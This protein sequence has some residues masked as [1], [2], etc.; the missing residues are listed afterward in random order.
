[1]A[2]KWK[3]TGDILD[4]CNCDPGCPCLFYSDPTKGHCDSLWAFH[5][6]TGNYGDVKLDGLN[7][8]MVTMSPG[9]FWKGNLK[10]AVYFDERANPKQREALET[11]FA[12][13][14]GGAP[15]TLAGLISNLLGT[16]YAKIEVDT[17]NRHARIPGILEFGLEPN[18]GGDKE[19][20][21]T[22]HHPFSPAMGTLNHGKGVDSHYTDF[23]NTLSGTGGDGLWSTFDFSGP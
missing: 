12:G 14:V 19:P 10:A 20:I 6:R 13:K 23:G 4:N 18:L 11:I 16:K 17:G 21:G 5:T 15:A 22:S 8:V 9:N 1:M 2:E 3:M 7:V